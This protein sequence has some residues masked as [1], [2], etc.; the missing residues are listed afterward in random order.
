MKC[1]IALLPLIMIN[2][3]YGGLRALKWKDKLDNTNDTRSISNEGKS[4]KK[5]DRTETE[6]SLDQSD[7]NVSEKDMVIGYT[8]K[9]DV[10]QNVQHEG[11]GNEAHG[12]KSQY[13]CGI[14]RRQSKI[15]LIYCTDAGDTGNIGDTAAKHEGETYVK[16]PENEHIAGIRGIISHQTTELTA[17][18]IACVDRVIDDSNFHPNPHTNNKL[19]LRLLSIAVSPLTTYDN[20][21]HCYAHSNVSGLRKYNDLLMV[22]FDF[23]HCN[24]NEHDCELIHLKNWNWL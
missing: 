5:H 11:E 19:V 1:I 18:Q 22:I 4:R 6:T 10:L 21:W 14:G 17:I 13:L 2:L 9:F 12:N 3:T 16:C 23:E 15:E 7:T 20:N 24:E 8:S